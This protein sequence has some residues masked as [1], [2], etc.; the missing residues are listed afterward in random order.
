VL[1]KCH[2]LGTRGVTQMSHARHMRCYTNVTCSSPTRRPNSSL[3]MSPSPSLSCAWNFARARSYALEHIQGTFRAHLG[4]AQGT[5]RECSGHSQ[6]TFS[7]PT[8][9][10]NI[11]FELR[12]MSVSP[13]PNCKKHSKIVPRVTSPAPGAVCCTLRRISARPHLC[14]RTRTGTPRTASRP[15]ESSQGSGYLAPDASPHGSHT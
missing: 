6:R 14:R 9:L 15:W 4:N 7:E 1:H 2:T 12:W 8:H 11:Q 13:H 10:G 3:L 5:F